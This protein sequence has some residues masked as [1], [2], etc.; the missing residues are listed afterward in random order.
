MIITPPILHPPQPTNHEAIL[1]AGLGGNLVHSYDAGDAGSYPGSGTTWFDLAGDT[2]L[3]MDDGAPTFNGVAGGRSAGEFFSFDG[4]SSFRAAANTTFL[5]GLHKL[6]AAHTFICVYWVPYETPSGSVR[7]WGTNV[8]QSGFGHGIRFFKS[9]TNGS[10]NRII[11][12]NNATPTASNSFASTEVTGGPAWGFAGMST[13]IAASTVTA[14]I[15][16]NARSSEGVSVASNTPSSSDASEPLG[17]GGYGAD[18]TMSGTRIA[19][20]HLFDTVLTAAE[21]GLVRTIIE[22]KY[23]L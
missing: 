1:F 16:W 13:S 9:D 11:S 2:D 21:M 14:N 17:V 7:L 20:F 5:N 18:H 6:N 8:T 4:S 19:S 22:D 10:A 12:R 23:G 15:N 3:E